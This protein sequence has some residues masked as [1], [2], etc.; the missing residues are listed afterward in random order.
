[1]VTYG[2]T[3]TFSSNIICLASKMV[4][5]IFRLTSAPPFLPRACHLLITN[6][7]HDYPYCALH[8]FHN[9]THCHKGSCESWPPAIWICFIR[10]HMFVL[11]QLAFYGQGRA[12][13]LQVGSNLL[14]HQLYLYFIVPISYCPHVTTASSSGLKQPD[15]WPF[16]SKQHVF[17]SPHRCNT[18]SRDQFVTAH[19]LGL[20]SCIFW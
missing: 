2:N 19:H 15:M 11:A 20:K 6:I 13:L 3:F 18:D 8:C 9:E 4:N 1:M 7:F 14:N 5:L 12:P 16:I 17:F 10:H